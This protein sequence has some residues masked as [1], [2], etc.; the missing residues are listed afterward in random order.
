M[1]FSPEYAVEIDGVIKSL[2]TSN[3]DRVMSEVTGDGDWSR[4]MKLR[5]FGSKRELLTWILDTAGLYPEGDGGQTRFDD[6]VAVSYEV[7]I[8]N[9]GAGLELTTNE[10][11]DNQLKDKPEVGALD[12]AQ[13]WAKDRA[14]EGVYNPRENLFKLITGGLDASALGYDGVRFFSD[15]HPVDPNN[16][17]GAKYSNI[18]TGVG[19]N[20]PA[21]GAQ[22]EQDALLLAGR[23]LAKARAAIRKQ[24]FINN[25]PRMLKPDILVCPTD[26]EYRGRQLLTLASMAATDN[27]NKDPKYLMNTSPF[28]APELDDEPDVYYIGVADMMQDELGAFMFNNRKDL[29]I[30]GYPS[31]ASAESN[32]SDLWSWF[33][34]GRRGF[35]YGHPYMF[36]RCEA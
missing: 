35:S 5:P 14:A 17:T 24:R 7:E 10:I 11:E 30:I 21:T 22:S 25:K 2:Y 13:R 9:L 4:L 26:L 8:E 3:W 33:Q 15:V 27:V 31:V 6:M 1:E 18:I 36:Y 20:A 32:R 19:I 12:Y 23:N 16:P 34:R 28:V 29:S